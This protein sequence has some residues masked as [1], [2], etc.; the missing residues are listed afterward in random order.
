[1]ARN[2]PTTEVDPQFSSAAA[3]AT[4][5]REARAQLDRAKAY[6]LSTV[7]PDGR[8]HVTTIA[9]IWLDDAL[10]FTT[11]QNERKAKN[12]AQNANVVVTTGTAAFEGLDVV[13]EGEAVRVTDQAT[14]ERLA[15]AY[16]P[17]YDR[18]FVFEA[19]DGELYTEGSADPALA[20]EVRATKAFGFAKG[21]L[22][23]QTRYRF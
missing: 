7:R 12:L 23:S 21:A 15:A 6:W 5:W 20:F 22:F 3:T 19:R 18:M 8:P 4:P 11:G 16:L 2:D 9:A 1:M 13:L 17:K 10:Y 14:L